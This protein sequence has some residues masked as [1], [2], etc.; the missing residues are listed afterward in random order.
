MARHHLS[1]AEEVKG[2][3]DSHGHPDHHKKHAVHHHKEMMK[4]IKEL[5]KH[6]KKGHKKHA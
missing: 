3:H 6:A 2:G 5:H 1:H 4:H